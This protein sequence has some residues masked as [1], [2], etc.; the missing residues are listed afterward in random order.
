[1]FSNINFIFYYMRKV[2]KRKWHALFFLDYRVFIRKNPIFDICPNC[3]ALATLERLKETSK[4]HRLPRFFGFKVYHCTTCKWDGYIYLYRRTTSLKKIILNYLFA[5][6]ALYL[7]SLILY[8]F[9]GDI[10]AAILG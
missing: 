4:I 2:Y 5:L 9:F 10:L 7:L 3:N 8:Y 1:M 6:F